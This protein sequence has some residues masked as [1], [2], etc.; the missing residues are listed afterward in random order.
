MP[1]GSVDRRVDRSQVGDDAAR[2]AVANDTQIRSPS[3]AQKSG[4]FPRTSSVMST[5][6]QGSA[7]G[8]RHTFTVDPGRAARRTWQ[9]AR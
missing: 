2:L 7:A 4:E 6:T 9:R 1:T 3:P 8:T 5:F